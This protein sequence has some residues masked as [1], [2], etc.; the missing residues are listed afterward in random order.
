MQEVRQ[1]GLAPLEKGQAS[2]S[3]SLRRS[4]RPEE[5]RTQRG[6]AYTSVYAQQLGRGQQPGARYPTPLMLHPFKIENSRFAGA[7]CPDLS[8]GL[9]KDGRCFDSLELC[10]LCF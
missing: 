4:Q 9:L 6:E 7:G 2:V 3:Q 1:E 10:W 5:V 8:N